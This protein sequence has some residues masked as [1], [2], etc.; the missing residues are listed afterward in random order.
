LSKP[1][2]ELSPEE[3]A[4]FATDIGIIYHNAAWVHSFATYDMLKETNV[5]A[6]VQILQFSVAKT[7]KNLFFISTMSV[8]DKTK[9]SSHNFKESTD[10]YKYEPCYQLGY[11]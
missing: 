9:E 10:L 6:T 2:F 4:A 1:Q 5:T 11:G 7:L 3:F 8:F